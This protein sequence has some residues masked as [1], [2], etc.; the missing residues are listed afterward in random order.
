[1]NWIFI[2]EYEFQT[3]LAKASWEHMTKSGEGV[4]P[5]K[6]HNSGLT[7]NIW[8]LWCWKGICIFNDMHG[9]DVLLLHHHEL[10]PV[11]QGQR[12]QAFYHLRV[13]EHVSKLPNLKAYLS[14]GLTLS[15]HTSSYTHIYACLPWVDAWY[16]VTLSLDLDWAQHG[17]L[18]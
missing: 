4:G 12:K 1:M 18:L 11:L 3:T 6:K 16:P 14:L 10:T 7:F 2:E 9:V 17:Q 8:C 13:T 5:F 15:C